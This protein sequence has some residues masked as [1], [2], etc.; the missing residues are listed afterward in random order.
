MMK[1]AKEFNVRIHT[2]K[3]SQSLKNEL[4]LWSHPN[5]NDF[6]RLSITQKEAKCM[7]INHKIKN[8][9]DAN[10]ISTNTIATHRPRK[11]C[12]CHKCNEMR[13]QS[14]RNPHKCQ[15]MAEKLLSTITP[16]WNP[17]NNPPKDNLDLT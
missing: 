13:E 3:P 7:Q 15:T 8:V 14:C 2:L 6:L 9:G 10:A 11:D 4:P 1:V 12:K 16:I 17:Q 5:A